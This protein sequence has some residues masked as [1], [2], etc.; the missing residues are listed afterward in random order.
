MGTAQATKTLRSIPNVHS[1]NVS[2]FVSRSITLLQT[3]GG[4][5]S[6]YNGRK[7]ASSQAGTARVGCTGPPFSFLTF[8]TC[9]VLHPSPPTL[10]MLRAHSG[11]TS[12]KP[13]SNDCIDVQ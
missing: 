8:P 9:V 4:G 2:R 10:K 11:Y 6:C 13:V 5:K 7:V 1:K 3:S 12:S